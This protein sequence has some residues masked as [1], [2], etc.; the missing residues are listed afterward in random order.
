VQTGDFVV[1]SLDTDVD[2][3]GV[4]YSTY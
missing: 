2:A 3:S 1:N 4:K